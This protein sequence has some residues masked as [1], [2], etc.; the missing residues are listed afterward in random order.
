MQQMHYIIVT[1]TVHVQY[2]SNAILVLQCTKSMPRMQCITVNILVSYQ[3]G[4]VPTTVLN[5][6]TQRQSLLNGPV[7]N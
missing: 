7:K 6:S 2:K 4:T 5:L 1:D 3:A